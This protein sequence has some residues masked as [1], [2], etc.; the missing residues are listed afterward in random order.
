M[1]T[2]FTWCAVI[3]GIVF[4]GQFALGL[5][6]H[7]HASTDAP[8]LDLGTPDVDIPHLDVDSGD[9]AIGHSPAADVWFVGMFS[10]RAVLAGITIFG[11][12]GRALPTDYADYERTL[13][14]LAA[15]G[16]TMYAM[17]WLVRRL[18]RLEHDGTVRLGDTLGT[19]GSVYLSIPEGGT[20]TG[21]VTLMVKGRTM[22]YSAVTPSD[23]LDT[24]TPVVVIAVHPPSTVE[25]EAVE[26]QGMRSE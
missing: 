8:A 23:R 2:F 13:L 19:E 5:L 20:G 15:G 11:L 18:H 14:A 6:G 10:L 22:E 16:W 26:G 1:D 3:G 12:V 4:L 25:V 7:G 21:K 24:G 9:T 17:G